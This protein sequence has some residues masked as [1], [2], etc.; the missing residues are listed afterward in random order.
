LWRLLSW[1]LRR[2]RNLIIV[3]VGVIVVVGGISRGAIALTSGGH[4]QQHHAG[5]HAAAAPPPS[6]SALS[7]RASAPPVS[8]S[9]PPSSTSSPSP[10]RHQPSATQVATRWATAF[11]AHKGK[12]RRQWRAGLEPYST[13][14]LAADEL[15]TVNPANV[16]GDAVTGRPT[17]TAR[18]GAA[19]RHVRVPTNGEDLALVLVRSGHRWRV[20][21]YQPAGHHHA[22]GH[23]GGR[24][25]HA[26]R[27]AVAGTGG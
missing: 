21:D 3:V 5:K 7:S 16:P 2:P 4:H 9:A 18:H 24:S 14:E 19:D 8:S 17:V 6:S 11:E 23:R 1:P 25:P 15:A 13:A 27:G 26:H 22:H 10:R 12:S 20:I